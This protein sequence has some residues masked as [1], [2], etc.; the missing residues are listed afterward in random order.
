MLTAFAVRLFNA[1]IL[2]DSFRRFGSLDGH[3]HVFRPFYCGIFGISRLSES[4]FSDQ[5]LKHRDRLSLAATIE[6]L[7]TFNKI[8]YIYIRSAM[9]TI[10]TCYDI[11]MYE[12]V[13]EQESP[14]M[15]KAISKCAFFVVEY[16]LYL[17]HS[18]L[19]MYFMCFFLCTYAR[20]PEKLEK[21]QRRRGTHHIWYEYMKTIVKCCDIRKEEHPP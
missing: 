5:S 3:L 2:C 15:S 12:F 13:T 10:T 9:A 20:A 14:E 16:L 21:G 6:F 11:R 19:P 17:K 18:I 1:E 4:R 7:L 8:I